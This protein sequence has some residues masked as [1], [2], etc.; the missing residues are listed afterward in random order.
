M[1][2]GG[3]SPRCRRC[4]RDL[5]LP[6]LRL[7]KLRHRQLE[8]GQEAADL[9][10]LRGVLGLLRDVADNSVED[11]RRQLL[12]LVLL[13]LLRLAGLGDLGR[14]G[15]N[16]NLDLSKLRPLLPEGLLK[17]LLL[18]LE[19]ANGLLDGRVSSPAAGEQLL[20]R[21]QSGPP[22]L[23]RQLIGPG[24]VHGRLRRLRNKVLL[25]KPSLGNLPCLHEGP[26]ANI[27]V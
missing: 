3:S 11:V 21:L 4:R 20:L 19:L 16:L 7:D 12:V 2:L 27:L 8:L 24:L 14:K 22:G 18:G 1:P 26:Q 13:G 9:L 6:G 25:P 5:S 15:R 17:L 10:E 23:G